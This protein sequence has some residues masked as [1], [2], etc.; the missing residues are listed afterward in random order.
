VE[1]RVRSGPQERVEPAGAGRRG[2]AANI[3]HGAD[4]DPAKLFTVVTFRPAAN[5]A[6][7][8]TEGYR[9]MVET[10]RREPDG[11]KRLGLYRQ[12]A[13]FVKD[14]AFVFPLALQVKSLGSSLERAWRR[15]GAMGARGPARRRHLDGLS[16]HVARQLKLHEGGSLLDHPHRPSRH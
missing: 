8:E 5:Q 6:H 13:A 10:A 3:Y 4:I 15:K 16:S 12:L 7:F 11:D 14:Q 2:D 1:H 9:Q